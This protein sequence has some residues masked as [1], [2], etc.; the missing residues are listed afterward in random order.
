MSLS[1][2]PSIHSVIHSSIHSSIYLFCLHS[3]IHPFTI[4]EFRFIDIIHSSSI[5]LY[6]HQSFICLSI[7]FRYELMSLCESSE[8]AMRALLYENLQPLDPTSV[9][10]APQSAAIASMEK[11]ITCHKSYWSNLQQSIHLINMSHAEAERCDEAI[12]AL[13]TL[14]VNPTV[15]RTF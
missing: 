12:S 15:K 8:S 11:T 3:S 9:N 10:R 2:T 4:N 6:I 7:K 13:A 14:S 1:F 5:Y